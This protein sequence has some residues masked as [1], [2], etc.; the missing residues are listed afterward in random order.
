MHSVKPLCVLCSLPMRVFVGCGEE[1][2]A[3]GR[4]SNERISMI[5]VGANYPPFLVGADY[6]RL[7]K[8]SNAHDIPFFSQV[9]QECKTTTSI[10]MI[11]PV[12][13]MIYSTLKHR[14]Y[15]V[16]K[17]E[18]F[19]EK[20]NGCLFVVTTYLRRGVLYKLI[21]NLSDVVSVTLCDKIFLHQLKKHLII[22][23]HFINSFFKKQTINV[24]TMSL[25]YTA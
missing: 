24:T 6:P 21:N 15:Y 9:C 2:G 3:A 5:P 12:E 14:C 4:Q 11:W 18:I 10:A 8:K 13:E 19:Q 20:E 25:Y 7:W 17:C 1:C 23:Y 16:W 22:C